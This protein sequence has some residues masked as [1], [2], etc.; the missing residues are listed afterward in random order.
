[1]ADRRLPTISL[2]E[3]CRGWLALAFTAGIFL[4]SLVHLRA[5]TPAAV[6][7][8]FRVSAKNPTADK[9][10]SKLWFAHGSWWAWLPDQQGSGVW[11]R[12]ED[13]WQR[14]ASLDAALAG[15]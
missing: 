8:T 9:P 3:R 1:M 5:A 11:R 15:L 10:Q 7:P 4:G 12:R 2:N 13:G 6:E 14:Q